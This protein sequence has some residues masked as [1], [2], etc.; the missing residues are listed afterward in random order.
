MDLGAKEREHSLNNLRENPG[1]SDTG[2]MGIGEEST[3]SKYMTFA[4]L[5][6]TTATLGF[7]YIRISCI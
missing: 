7:S 6:M 1:E 3:G 4:I 5:C 2:P